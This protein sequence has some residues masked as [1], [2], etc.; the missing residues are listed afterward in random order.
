MEQT[1]QFVLT[2]SMGK[3]L[4]GRGLAAH[5]A[6]AA[7]L[8]KGTLAIIAGTTNAYVAEEILATL[9]QGEG[10]ARKGFRRGMTVPP[11]FNLAALRSE[12][13]GDVIVVDGKYRPGKTIFDVADSLAA[14]DIVLKGANA[15]NV[16]QRAAAVYIGDRKAGTIG[17]VLGAVVGR[18]VRLIVP[19]GLEKRVIEPIADLAALINA[20]TTQGPG[21]LPLPGEPFTELD[22]IAT[23]TGAT[24]RLLAAGG[25]CGAEGAIWLGVSGSAEQLE[26]AEAILGNLASEPMYHQ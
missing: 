10:F 24:G 9:G 19:V 16:A 4:I 25:T 17:A 22:A 14:G 18:R 5:P 26:K 2:P 13:A 12:F 1:R 21:L 11:G 23:L 7:V 8:K 3:R 15:L 20:P 6:I